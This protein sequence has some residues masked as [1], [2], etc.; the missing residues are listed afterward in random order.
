MYECFHCGN[1][2]VIWDG[3]FSFEEMMYEMM[4]KGEGIVH[5]CHCTKC[6]AEIEYRVPL[7]S[8]DDSKEA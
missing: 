5:I 1:K 7:S 6:G 8:S 3:D 4:Y 2:S